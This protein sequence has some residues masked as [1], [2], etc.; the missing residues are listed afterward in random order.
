MYEYIAEARK[1]K[2]KYDHSL[3]ILMGQYSVQTEIEFISG[4]IMSWPKYLSVKDRLKFLEKLKLAYSRFREEWRQH[5]ELEFV[6]YDG[7]DIQEKIQAKAAACENNDRPLK[8]YYL[9]AVPAEKIANAA[10][11]DTLLFV[12]DDEDESDY[13]DEDSVDE[14]EEEDH[15]IIEHQVPVQINNVNNNVANDGSTDNEVQ[16]GEV[17]HFQSYQ[18]PPEED[19]D[20]DVPVMSIKLSELMK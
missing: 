16:D 7:E 2:S 12:S 17:I 4:H 19:E 15:I 20:D 1:S 3:R 9:E 11:K 6:D 5:F 13:E 10:K 18:T 14:S 8:D